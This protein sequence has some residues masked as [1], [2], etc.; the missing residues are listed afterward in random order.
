MRNLPKNNSTIW[1][2]FFLMK[3]LPAE[4]DQVNGKK[5]A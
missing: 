5:D 2:N 1:H 3:Q 4:I